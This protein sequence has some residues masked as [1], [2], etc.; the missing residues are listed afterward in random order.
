MMPR[1][2]KNEML[3]R[4]PLAVRV[5]KWMI[6]ELDQRGDRTAQVEQAILDYLKKNKNVKIN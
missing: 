2:R 3:V 4:Q 1:P 5:P 6:V